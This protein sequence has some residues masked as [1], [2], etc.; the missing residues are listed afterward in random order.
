[1]GKGQGTVSKVWSS[2]ELVDGGN[3]AGDQSKNGNKA[4]AAGRIVLWLSIWQIIN[5]K[6][7][8]VKR[9][10]MQHPSKKSHG[11]ERFLVEAQRIQRDL[12]LLIRDLGAFVGKPDPRKPDLKVIDPASGKEFRK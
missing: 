12:D 11:L 1:M 7:I 10:R 4:Q 6:S 8:K 3:A 2:A 9:N 5:T